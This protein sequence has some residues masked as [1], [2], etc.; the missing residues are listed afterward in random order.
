[1]GMRSYARS[2]MK[3]LW[4]WSI[5]ISTM[6]PKETRNQRWARILKG[7]AQSRSILSDSAFDALLDMG[8]D[9]NAQGGICGNA[10]ICAILHEEVVSPLFDQAPKNRQPS[11]LGCCMN[12]GRICR[13]SFQ[14]NFS[15]FSYL[16][17]RGAAIEPTGKGKYHNALQAASLTAFPVGS[18]AAPRLSR[19]ENTEKLS[20][21]DEAYSTGDPDTHWKQDHRQGSSSSRV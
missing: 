2:Y 8:A 5:W 13:V 14:V 19:Y 16:L 15:V 10:L 4:Y 11:H 12:C 18:M 21:A 7:R 3:R 17:K 9:V 6:I 20:P 1:V